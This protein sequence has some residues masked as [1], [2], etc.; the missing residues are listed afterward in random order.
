LNRSVP[1]ILTSVRR[2]PVGSAKGNLKPFNVTVQYYGEF[3]RGFPWQI[4]GCGTYRNYAT[5]AYAN[6]LLAAYFDRLKNS[7]KAPV[8]YLAVAER[9]TSG[10]GFPAIPL[11]WHFVMSVPPQHTAE[12]M[13]NAQILWKKHYGEVK[14]EPY[15][16]ERYGAYYLAKSAGEPN[17]EYRVHN[18]DKLSYMGPSDLFKNS[19]T[20]PYVPGHARHMTHGETLSIRRTAVPDEASQ[21][22][23]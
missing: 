14:I 11:H 16:R 7:I 4:I 6:K 9:R 23:I 8:A 18:L 13:R 5:V 2:Y 17:F 19:Q 22:N 1:E 10:L 21:A 20:D 15:D 12:T 3:F